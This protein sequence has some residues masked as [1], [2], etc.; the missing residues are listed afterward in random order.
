MNNKHLSWIKEINN[1]FIIAP[2]AYFLQAAAPRSD[3]DCATT[4]Q[5]IPLLTHTPYYSAAIAA[6]GN[7]P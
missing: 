6:E 2:R 7:M 5:A 1:N 3:L 4:G